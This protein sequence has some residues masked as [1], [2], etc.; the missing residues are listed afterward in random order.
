MAQSAGAATEPVDTA[1]QSSGVLGD[2]VV[3]AQRRSE[4]LQDVPIAVSVI[5]GN[6]ALDK[7]VTST[8]DLTSAVPGLVV[9]YNA[10]V[11]NLYLRGVGSNLPNPT[12]E[13]PTAT[14]VDGVY[15]PFPQSNFFT[16]YD[17]ERIEVLKGPQ[18]TLFGRNATGGVVQ[19]ITK[20]PSQETELDAS[21]T[22]GNYNTVSLQA[23]GTTGLGDKAAIGVSAQY[24]NQGKGFGRNLTLNEPAFQRAI[25]SYTVRAKLLVTPTDTTKI[26]VT[27]DY[28]NLLN[29][30]GY[31]L[32]PGVIGG[33]GVSTYPGKFNTLNDLPTGNPLEM[34]GV[35]FKLNQEIGNL[36]FTAISGYRELTGTFFSDSDSTPQPLSQLELREKGRAFSQELQLAGSSDRF[37]WIVGLYYFDIFG[38]GQLFNRATPIIAPLPLI[39][40]QQ[41]GRSIAGF[42]QGT[43]ELGGGTSVT[44][45]ARYTKEWQDFYYPAG[46]LRS[47]QSFA[48][49]S[50]RV[51]IDHKFSDDL[52]V[53]VSYNNSFKGGGYN[54][55]SPTLLS[56]TVNNFQPEVLQSFEGGLKA[57]LFDGRMRLNIAAFH[58]LYD[59]I[60]TALV[61]PG[62][63][64]TLNAAKAHT[65]GLEIDFSAKPT[66]FLELSGAFSAMR[67]KYDRYPN[68]PSIGADAVQRTV[69]ASGNDLLVLPDYTATGTATF[70]IPLSSG[71]LRPSATISYNDGFFWFADNRLRS[72]AYTLINAQLGWTSDN[73]QFGIRLWARNLTNK[74]YYVAR[75]SRVRFGD[76]QVPAAPRTY[77]ITLTAKFR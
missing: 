72:P 47:S 31:Q 75:L 64:V 77:G 4:R 25:D 60:Q 26:L 67:G 27:A 16:F 28:S 42:A 69:D 18:G 51:A 33:D 3:T 10:N 65:T 62:G 23:Y 54:L 49:P 45:G 22:Y 48:K 66:D 1:S 9:N 63:V 5:S 50:W 38:R 11:G 15:I 17:V 57:Q 43:L 56:G 34:Y 71:T 13:Q 36:D 24:D 73:E 19:I 61:I 46:N 58:Y 55:I 35:S 70:N 21:L 74:Y 7:G 68:A 12:D 32:M 40:S 52:M 2:I 20:D 59:D 29:S 76:S 44:A 6:D 30:S 39:G 41:E 53:Y 14:Y 37:N 8:V